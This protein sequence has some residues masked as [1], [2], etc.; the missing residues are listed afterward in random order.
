MKVN[1]VL[2][3][4]TA[5]RAGWST[6]IQ[7]IESKFSHLSLAISLLCH[8][9]IIYK[10]YV[11]TFIYIYIY[12]YYICMYK[13]IYIV[14]HLYITYLYLYLSVSIPIYSIQICVHLKLHPSLSTSDLCWSFEA[15][16]QTEAFQRLA[17]RCAAEQQI[18]GTSPRP[19]VAP[20]VGGI[21]VGN[22]QDQME[23]YIVGMGLCESYS[24]RSKK[25]IEAY[26]WLNGIMWD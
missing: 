17:G 11:K 23:L 26:R 6:N 14:I 4:T 2:Q 22:I 5:Q 20:L 1:P 13:Y 3:T 9:Y 16:Q 24:Y 18:L 10:K 19:T 25:V 7:N 8:I 12:P 21:F 15:S